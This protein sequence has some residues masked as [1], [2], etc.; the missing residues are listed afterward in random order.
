M[1][2]VTRCIAAAVLATTF[3]TAGALPGY[4]HEGR[5]IG[6]WHFTVGWGEE[7]SYAGKQNSVLLILIDHDDKPVVDLGDTLK[8]EV[9]F[10]SDKR[11]L[12]LEPRFRVGAFGTPGDY[13]AYLTPTRAGTYTFTFTGTIKGD[14]INAKFTCGEKTFDCAQDPSEIEFPAKDPSNAQLAERIDREVP[15]LETEVKKVAAVAK[16]DAKSA[17]TM[18]LVGIIVGAV[19]LLIAL[20][21]VLSGRRK[22]A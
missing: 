11:T 10:G 6:R 3:L 13:R 14:R 22:T 20:I 8:V 19:G 15:R 9:A 2:I 21:A 1:R 4:A 17:N 12:S 16:D 18:G 5:H 7:P